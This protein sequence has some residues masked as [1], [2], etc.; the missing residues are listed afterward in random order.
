MM[1]GRRPSEGD[2]SYDL[3]EFAIKH[4]LTEKSA[5]IV[6]AINGPSRERCDAAAGAFKEALDQRQ[7]KRHTERLKIE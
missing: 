3:T 1:Q 5:Q 7:T 4:G 6:L 2:G